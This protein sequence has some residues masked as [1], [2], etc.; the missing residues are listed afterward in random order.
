[1]NG[2]GFDTIYLRLKSHL[3]EHSEYKPKVQTTEVGTIYPKVVVSEIENSL[4]GRT[5][6]DSISLLGI[7]IKIYAKPMNKG[8]I[9]YAGRTIAREI[10]DHVDVVCGDIYG[11]RRVTCKPTPVIDG[12]DM[13]CITMRYNV[14]QDDNRNRFY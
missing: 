4:I 14:K 8:T 9:T 11:M 12:E 1:M 7:E 10:R 13:Y 3:N 5:F 2:H 6:S